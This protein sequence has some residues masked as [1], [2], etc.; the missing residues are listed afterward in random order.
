MVIIDGH[1]HALKQHAKRANYQVAIR[2]PSL[3]NSPEV[4]KATDG[5]G[6]IMGEDGQ[7]EIE[8]ITGKPA[9]E[10]VLSLMPCKCARSC[11]AGRCQCIDQGLPCSHA[12]KFLDCDNMLKDNEDL[13]IIPDIVMIFDP[14]MG[15][16]S[17]IDED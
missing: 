14:D 10:M 8:W 5:Y 1:L 17:D 3:Q 6:W 4:P 12:C 11:N 9:P 16:V 13:K 2:R 15:D 7:I